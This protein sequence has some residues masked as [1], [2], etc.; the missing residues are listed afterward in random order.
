MALHS[1]LHRNKSNALSQAKMAAEAEILRFQTELD[2]AGQMA[3][4]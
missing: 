4:R 3:D 1:T 2:E